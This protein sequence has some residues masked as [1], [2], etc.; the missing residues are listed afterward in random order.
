MGRFLG[1]EK[2][3]AL[4]ND[5]VGVKAV[6]EGSIFEIALNLESASGSPTPKSTLST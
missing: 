6:E 3:R 2:V 4:Y 5:R 1:S